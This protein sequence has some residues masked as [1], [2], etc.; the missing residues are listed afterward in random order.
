M[1]AMV[2]KSLGTALEPTELPDRRP[3]PGEIRVKVGACGVCRTDLH[4]VDGELPGPKLP[5]I[6]GHE[7]VGRIDQLGPGVD[8]LHMGERVGIPWLGH[9]CGVC[10]YCKAHR[11]NLCDQPLFTGFTRDGGFATAT[12]ADARYAFLLGETGDDAALAPLLCAGLIGWRSLGLAGDGKALGLYGF[13]AAAHIIAQVASCQGRSV[14]AFIRV[15]GDAITSAFFA[16]DKAKA[17]EK[18]RADI[19]SQISGM[20]PRWDLLEA[21]IG[22]LRAG[23]RGIMPFHW[24]VEFPEVFSREN[25]GFDAVIGN[26]PFLG[27]TAIS[28]N[29]G[30]NYFQYLIMRNV[31]AEHHC[32]LVAYFFRTAFRLLRSGGCL[33]LIATNTISQ[34]DTRE[35]GL[36]PILG[37]GGSIIRAVRRLR[38]PG[39][40]AVVVSVVHI[41]QGPPALSRPNLTALGRTESPPILCKGST[42]IL[43]LHSQEIPIFP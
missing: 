42:I 28:Q 37:A 39:E 5:I 2:L 20:P 31:P 35:G 33:G 30:M 11:E 9:T 6:P 18:A 41:P 12:I 8:G 4:V 21:A 22:K 36:A 38:W 14:F 15:V 26:P 24:Q 43:Q 17:R 34:G 27:G 1:L 25:G 32:D 3:G 19:E 29:Y 10:S 7:I 40:A 23:E 13:G 16:A